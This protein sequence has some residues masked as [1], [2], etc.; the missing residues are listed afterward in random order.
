MIKEIKLVKNDQNLWACFVRKDERWGYVIN[1]KLSDMAGE[2][3]AHVYKYPEEAL[4]HTLVFLD[5][6]D[7]NRIPK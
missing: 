4:S 1:E 3:M 5:S 7:E 2:N 6:H